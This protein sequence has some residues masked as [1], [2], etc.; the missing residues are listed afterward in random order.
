VKFPTHRVV[1]T[2]SG[3]APMLMID[4][5]FF[6][7]AGV[8]WFGIQT[9][10]F[11]LAKRFLEGEDIRPLLDERAAIGFNDL[12]VWILN[13]SVVGQVYPGG[14][15]PKQYPDF[16]DRIRECLELCG[17]YGFAVEV[18]AFTQAGVILPDVDDQIAHWLLTQEMVR[19]LPHVRLELVNEYDHGSAQNAPDR[20]L[21][22]MRPE[23][24]IAS[25]GSSTADAAPSEPVW[26]YVCYHTNGLNEW[27]RRVGHNTMEWADIYKRP[28]CANENMRYPDDDDLPLHAYDAAAG[29][30]LLCASA[31]YHSQSGKYSR[32][33]DRVER[34]A[35]IAWVDGARSVPL[36]FQAGRYIRR[37]DLLTSDVIRAYERRLS[38]GRGHVVLIHA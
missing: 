7:D 31:C 13:E 9:S 17:S 4:G 6:R 21:W 36:E 5:L 30:A 38:D 37:D 10:E 26:D 35:A 14:I 25:S 2:A 33:F 32:T 19:G 1:S 29:A 8:R 20:Q 15:H 27:Q 18:T 3:V 34:D 12:R 28:G 24:I 16:Y 11:T 22:S 23:G